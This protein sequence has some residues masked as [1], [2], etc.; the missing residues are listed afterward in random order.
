MV[1][2]FFQANWLHVASHWGPTKAP[3][4]HFAPSTAAQIA[5]RKFYHE[6]HE[7]EESGGWGSAGRA[8]LG[9]MEYHVPSAALLASLQDFAASQC[10]AFELPD[11][12]LK[13]A[14]RHFDLRVVHDCN[15]LDSEV[16]ARSAA[17]GTQWLPGCYP[18]AP[19]ILSR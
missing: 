16:A 14:I 10:S 12:A 7:L 19:R 15:V 8:A 6:L 13:C 18:P 9:K 1:Y 11:H 5:F 17:R 2:P 3:A 4:A